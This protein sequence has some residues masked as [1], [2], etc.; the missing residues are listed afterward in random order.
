MSDYK[1]CD[2]AWIGPIT[3]EIWPDECGRWARAQLPRISNNQNGEKKAVVLRYFLVILHSW[4]PCFTWIM[5]LQAAPVAF[6]TLRFL[7]SIVWELT[8]SACKKLV[9]GYQANQY[10]LLPH[11]FPCST[12]AYFGKSHTII[13][14]ILKKC[15]YYVEFQKV[16]KQWKSRYKDYNFFFYFSKM[17]GSKI[18]KK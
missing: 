15:K 11:T 3:T 8:G 13:N 6:P 10:I 18:K 2:A 14:W 4:L 12:R 16:Q 17:H 1:E 7:L 9:V 5:I